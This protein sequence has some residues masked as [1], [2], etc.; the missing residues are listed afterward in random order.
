M[1]VINVNITLYLIRLKMELSKKHIC[2]FFVLFKEKVLL[3]H[4]ELFV[5]YMVKTCTNWFK[6]FKNGDFDISDKEYSGR[7][8]AVEEDELRKDGKKSRKMMKNTFINLYRIDF[9]IVIKKLLKINK[10]VWTDLIWI[11]FLKKLYILFF[12]I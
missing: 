6:W 5:S 8:A 1:S 4:T 10:N 2:L 11:I 3:I 12:V 7:L 9:F